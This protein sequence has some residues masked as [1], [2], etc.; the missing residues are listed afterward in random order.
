MS[1]NRVKKVRTPLAYIPV[2]RGQAAV[3]PTENLPSPEHRGSPINHEFLLA[4]HARGLAGTLS[5]S[6]AHSTPRLERAASIPWSTTRRRSKT[7]GALESGETSSLTKT[8]STS[9]PSNFQRPCRSGSGSW[10]VDHVTNSSIGPSSGS[11][12]LQTVPSQAS[13]APLAQERPSTAPNATLEVI[14]PEEIR[15]NSSFTSLGSEI[16]SD[17][18]VDHLSVIGTPSFRHFTSDTETEIDAHIATVSHLNNAANSI[19][20]L[21]CRKI[22]CT[23]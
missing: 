15:R 12:V 21:V 22:F 16:H 10:F 19:L 9:P 18:I 5:A 8:R 6:T 23:V 4:K 17:S 3:V 1:S 13:S 2:Q 14:I 11:P 7:L 20:M